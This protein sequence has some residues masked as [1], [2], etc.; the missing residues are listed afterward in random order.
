MLEP[1]DPLLMSELRLAVMS[2]LM[3]V[4]EADFLYIKEE[5]GATAGNLSVQIDK[6]QTAGYIDVEKGFAGK[7]T[8]TVCRITEGGRRAFEK[9]F[10]ALGTYFSPR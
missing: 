10:E 2:I 1:L 4:Q 3:Y 6:L 9:H 5:T 7:R 8:R